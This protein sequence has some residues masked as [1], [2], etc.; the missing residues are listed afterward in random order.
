MTMAAR[1]LVVFLFK[2]H[3]PQNAQ[4]STRLYLHLRERKNET[5]SKQS[6]IQ[7]VS[8]S[9]IKLLNKQHF[10]VVMVSP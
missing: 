1:L 2:C 3:T 10:N 5:K 9:D 6:T 8:V 7:Y 4:Y